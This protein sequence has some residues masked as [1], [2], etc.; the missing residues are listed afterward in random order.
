MS[1]RA[2]LCAL[3]MVSAGAACGD[4]VAPVDQHTED[5]VFAALLAQECRGG[6]RPK[7]IQE[8]V[9]AER[10]D[11]STFKYLKENSQRISDDLLRSLRDSN[12]RSRQLSATH[13]LAPGCQYVGRSEAEA[14]QSAAAVPRDVNLDPWD[15]PSVVTFSRV[16]VDAGESRAIVRR[17]S[18]NGTFCLGEYYVLRRTDGEWNVEETVQYVVC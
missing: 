1:R 9:G 12:R 11:R 3:L 8:D 4:G 2:L 13:S 10:L 15:R 16:G 17:F 5:S 18:S 14:R 7:L 6:E